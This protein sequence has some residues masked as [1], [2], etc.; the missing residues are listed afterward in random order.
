MPLVPQR[1]Q[2]PAREVTLRQIQQA[3][4]K[5]YTALASRARREGWPSRPDPRRDDGNRAGTRRLYQID[6]L[7]PDIRSTVRAKQGRRRP[8]PPAPPAAP[9]IPA[10]KPRKFLDL[11]T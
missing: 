4:G 6:A 2:P 10:R 11:S 9:R 8:L 3:T 1:S 7:P 5:T